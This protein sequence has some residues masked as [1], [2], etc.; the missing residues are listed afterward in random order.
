MNA[1]WE[2]GGIAPL[3]LDL[4]SRLRWVVS[5]TARP[6]YPH[7][8]GGLLSRSGRG[9]EEKNSQPLPGLEHLIDYRCHKYSLTTLFSINSHVNVY[10]LMLYITYSLQI[11]RTNCP[12]YYKILPKFLKS[13]DSSVGI[14]LGCGLDYRGST[15]RFPAGTGNFSLHRRVQNGSGAHPASYPTLT[16]GSFPGGRAAGHEADHSPPSSAKVKNAWSYTS[17][18]PIRLHGAVLS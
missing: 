7:W 5:C 10:K 8:L 11:D 15:V 3:I 6:L 1:Y 4:G 2:S 13:R 14:A 16:R 18:P 17:A 9:G 12:R